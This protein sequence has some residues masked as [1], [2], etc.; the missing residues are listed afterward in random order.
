MSYPTVDHAPVKL[1]VK[2]ASFVVSLVLETMWQRPLE[3]GE[4]E[5]VGCSTEEG[6][7]NSIPWAQLVS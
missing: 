3:T 6:S 1:G 7:A 4:G 2:P 5:R